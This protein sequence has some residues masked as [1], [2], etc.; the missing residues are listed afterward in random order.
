M[1]LSR[2]WLWNQYRRHVEATAPGTGQADKFYQNPGHFDTLVRGAFHGLQVH[3]RPGGR[4]GEHE[5]YYERLTCYASSPL[6]QEWRLAIVR[7]LP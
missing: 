2:T 1:W 6:F 7:D 5:N 3:T 4:H